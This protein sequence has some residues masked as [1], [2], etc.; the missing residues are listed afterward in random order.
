MEIQDS[1]LFSFI[2]INKNGEEETKTDNQEFI[3]IYEKNPLFEHLILH[4][5]SYLN[6]NTGSSKEKE[7]V[8]FLS[9]FLKQNKFDNKILKRIIYCG[10]PNQI[11]CLRAMIWK[12][13]VGYL[14]V[15]DLSQWK[16]I[17]C[18]HFQKYKALQKEFKEFPDNITDE[19]DDKIIVQ[20]DKDLHRTRGE[21]EFF[22]N[23]SKMNK[24]ETNYDVL[25]RILY[26]YSKK[27]PEVSY[28][29]GMNE[30][31]AIIYYI[32]SLDESPYIK[33]F[34]ESDAY[35]TFELLMDEVK[36]VF[37]MSNTTYSQL[38]ISQQIKQVND[39]LKKVGPDLYEYF[40]K[41]NLKL[42]TF[43]MRWIIVLF[44]REFN[45]ETSVCFWDRLF[46]QKNK[47]KFLGF[48]SAT[49]LIINKEKLM[50]MEMEDIFFW[51]QEFGSVVNDTN[52][53]S[54]II[55]AFKL[56]AK[57]NNKDFKKSSKFKFFNFIFNGK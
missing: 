47:M 9:D 50:K 21:L 10:I 57:Y 45:L 46:T 49:I 1:S 35:Y 22:K 2:N 44:A 43:I 6:K 32:Y 5:K 18:E 7:K 42:D 30:I 28:V 4:I 17:T 11:P 48:I 39:I 20:I 53:D 31:C 25:R 19:E 54:I 12:S 51:A 36:C 14:P 37:M 52:L 33:P 8:E 55:K 38:F 16:K 26:L 15:N 56:K 40:E 13:L 41:K 3:K 23:S 34:I 29:Q 27:H 24:K